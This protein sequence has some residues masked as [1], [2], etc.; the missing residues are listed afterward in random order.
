MCELFYVLNLLRGLFFFFSVLPCLHR[1]SVSL[2]TIVLDRIIMRD[3]CRGS[4]TKKEDENDKTNNLVWV[5][6]SRNVIRERNEM[7]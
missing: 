2:F 7:S 3:I 1:R 6:K 4:S 5:D